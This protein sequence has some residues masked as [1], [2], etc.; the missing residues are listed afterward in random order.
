[1]EIEYKSFKMTL[2]WK[3]G[4]ATIILTGIFLNFIA[5]IYFQEPSLIA[6]SGQMVNFEV[7]QANNTVGN[8]T[9]GVTP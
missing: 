2:G 7:T 4:L 1:M 3:A 9:R 6:D 5:A 8:G